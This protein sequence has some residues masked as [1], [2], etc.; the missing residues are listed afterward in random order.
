MGV[1]PT[2]VE[3]TATGVDQL[4]QKAEPVKA[5]AQ[6]ES[7]RAIEAMHTV[8]ASMEKAQESIGNFF[9][10]V[11]TPENP[12]M[13]FITPIEEPYPQKYIEEYRGQLTDNGGTDATKSLRYVMTT[14]DGFYAHDLHEGRFYAYH[15]RKSPTCQGAEFRQIIENAVNNKGQATNI[16]KAPGDCIVVGNPPNEQNYVF[17]EADQATVYKAAQLSIEA[18]QAKER[19]REQRAQETINTAMSVQKSIGM[20]TRSKSDQETAVGIAKTRSVLSR[21]FSR[22][23]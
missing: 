16:R 11:G 6:N 12:A 7:I 2:Q 4:I 14:K 23:K 5:K 1:N 19:P 17:Q 9:V 15:Q 20:E 8:I 13:I 22:G 3:T 18:A 10:S 21:L